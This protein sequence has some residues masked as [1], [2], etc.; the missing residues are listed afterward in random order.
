MLQ[1]LS[2]LRRYLTDIRELLVKNHLRSIWASILYQ[3]S[4]SSLFYMVGL[5][6]LF[7]AGLSGNT[8]AASAQAGSVTDINVSTTVKTPNAKR[9]GINLSGQSFYD[10][11][12]MLR[13]VIFR[14]PGF[15]GEIWRSVLKCKTVVGDGCY[16]DDPWSSWPANFLQG[17]T[18][19]FITGASKGLTG[20]ISSLDIANAN[21]NI[22]TLLHMSGLAHAPTAGDYYVVQATIRGNPQAGW[23]PST[24]GGATLTADTSD[25]SPNSPGKQA[26]QMNATS[27]GQSASVASFFDT[28]NGRSFL[29]MNGTYTLTFRAKGLGG[30]NSLSVNVSRQ[31]GPKHGTATYLNQN[32]SL[33]NQWHDY[34]FSFQASEDGSY[35]GVAGVTFAIS[36]GSALLDD[37][38][39]TEEA[40]SD[41]PTPFRNAVVD[42]LRELHPGVLRYMDNGTDFGSTIDNMIAV[43]FARQRAGYSQNSAE[44]DDIPIGLEE[45]L[46]LCHAIDAEPWFTVPNAVSNTEMQNLIQFLNGDASTKYGAMRA[47]LGQSAPW[48]SV[49]PVIHLELGNENWNTG[50]FPGETINDP[51]GNGQR[52]QDVFT[53]ARQA[54]EYDPSKFDLIMNGWAVVPWYNQQEL[55]QTSAADTIDVAP[56]T[57]NALND[58]GSNEAIYGSMFAEPEAVDSLSNGYMYQQM[59]TAAAASHPVKLAVYE[60]NLSTVAGTASQSMVN[61]VVPSVGA[62]LSI[63]EH[64]LLMMRDDGVTLQGMFALPEYANGFNNT[65]GGSESTPLWGSVIDMGGATNQCRPQFLAEALANTAITGNL[66]E[67]IQTGANPTWNQPTNNNTKIA[68]PNAHYLQSFAFSDGSNNGVIVFNLHRTSALPVTFSGAKAPKGTVK[69]GQLTSRNITDNNEQNNVVSATN[70][71]VTNFDP[72]KSTS[73]PPFSMTVF[74]WGGDSSTPAAA[75]ATKS[76][77]TASPL[78]ITAGQTATLAA[79]VTASSGTPDGSVNVLDGSTSLGV[80]A[81]SKGMATV[82]TTALSAGVHTLTVNYQGSSSY[83]ASTSPAVTVS[84]SAA[85]LATTTTLTPSATKLNSNQPLTLNAAVSAP[86]GASVPTGNVIF[87]LGNQSV[88]TASLAAGKASVSITGPSNVGP[89]RISAKYQGNATDS[90]SSSGDV[91]ISVAASQSQTASS[92]TVSVTPTSAV[93]GQNAVLSARVSP[94]SGTTTPIGSVQFFLGANSIGSA[95]LSGGVATVSVPAPAAGIYQLSAKYAGSSAANASTSSNV[96]WVV[97]AA[98]ASA[99]ATTTQLQLSA[100]N[101]TV[102]DTVNI[103]VAITSANGKTAPKGT[104]SITGSPATLTPVAAVNGRA[105]LQFGARKVGVFTL[106]ADFT[107]DGKTSG[108]SVS[109]AVAL[110]VNPVMIAAPGQPTPT[111]TP[112]PVP[113]PTPTPTPAPTPAGNGSVSL[114]LSTSSVALQPGETSPVNV[115]LTPKNGFS[116]TVDL[117]CNGLPANVAC[118]FEPAS[119]PVANNPAS[120]TMNVSSSNATS[121][122]ASRAGLSGIAYGAMLPWNLIAMLATA[123]AR[124]RKKLGVLRTLVLLVLTGAGAMAMSGCGVSYNTVAQ[125]YHVTLTATANGATVNTTAFD[126]VLKEKTTPW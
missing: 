48:T 95:A 106:I 85:A 5:G 36:G 63:A 80:A 123:L 71:S 56:Y 89:Y 40:A 103:G 86:D 122:A 70:T 57:F 118:S 47:S 60:V 2:H 13:N 35:V 9:L 112:T 119:L 19:R 97:S 34:T 99:V 43:P 45:F 64:M 25:L 30:S 20:T 115:Q 33:T 125:T 93:Q 102:G 90:G 4:S 82:T 21:S 62:G 73:L 77:L 49:F 11:G 76:Q 42:R 79:S 98:T 31:S 50:S 51:V 7:L 14:N 111:P 24:S 96:Q 54:P 116:Q 27:S 100:T 53:A 113:T 124:K 59:Q 74:T 92:T 10:S 37:A 84:V 87:Y 22:S 117:N 23:W 67:T 91:A 12:Q 81:L 17:A 55:L 6:L 126:V 3:F 32:V 46:E 75:Q 110:T 15:E 41:N 78:Q 114:Q 38:A 52:A 107:G 66:L 18:V 69:I 26:L 16:A 28:M 109:K 65:N 39:L 72:T 94:S 58:Y 101:V 104:V 121:A 88:G 108:S 105:A 61:R 83:L 120:T 1:C 44:Q 29:Q 8:T 68:T